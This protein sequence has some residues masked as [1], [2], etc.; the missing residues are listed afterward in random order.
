MNIF[1]SLDGEG[2]SRVGFLLALALAVSLIGLSIVAG[3]ASAAS[4]TCSGSV[5][6]D[7]EHAAEN[8]LEYSVKCNE[9]ILGY[10]IVS[11]REIGYFSTEV[12]VFAGEEVAEGEAFTCEGAIPGN[13]VGCYGKATAG[14]TAVGSVGTTDELCE[15]AVQPRFWAV[16]L[17]TQ[18]KKEVPFQLTSEPF[19]LA[20]RCD[21][22]NAKKKA[23][24]AKAKARAVCAKV[25]SSAPGKARD[26]ARKR[27]RSAIAASKK[28]IA[29]AEQSPVA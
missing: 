17:T 26:K 15:A 6:V 5:A 1:K 8:S 24:D 21:T 9:D 10:S 19:P 28:A 3:S 16:A 12:T 11:N 13:G 18:L 4:V 25:K 27:C 20:I 2:E 22:L 7:E 23:K 14:N 29:T